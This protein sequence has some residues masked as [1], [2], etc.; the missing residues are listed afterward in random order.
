MRELETAPTE[1][2]DDELVKRV[3]LGDDRLFAV[4][5][6]RHQKT[7]RR[8]V[9][10][11]I[12]DT[13]TVD[14]VMQDTS[15]SAFVHLHELSGG[16]AFCV[17]LRRIAFHAACERLRRARQSPFVESSEDDLP[18]PHSLLACPEREAGRSELRAALE[19]AV[20]ALSDDYREVF[21]LRSVH[22][23]SVSETA[24]A[25]GVPVQTVKTRHFRA[26]G[27][28]Q[29]TLSSWLEQPIR[30]QWSRSLVNTTEV[31]MG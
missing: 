12:R 19:R 8:V 20:Q 25:I 21:M 2:S 18:E 11:M 31:A 16:G 7:A 29:Q 9:D 27:K 30:S 15:V 22:G 14:D 1:L 17:W 10:R 24:T 26:R 23:F 13:S 6:G 3:Q 5:M 28:L 4:L